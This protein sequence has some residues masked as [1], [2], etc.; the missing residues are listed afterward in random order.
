VEQG[1]APKVGALIDRLADDE[2]NM[3]SMSVDAAL[4][5]L[6]NPAA[7]KPNAA[8]ETSVAD[9]SSQAGKSQ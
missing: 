4:T 5:S 9:N 1:R 7:P 6:T 3:L 2:M 8:V